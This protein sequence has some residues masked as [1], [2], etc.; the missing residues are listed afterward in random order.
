MSTLWRLQLDMPGKKPKFTH[1]C[2]L[3]SLCFRECD[4][5]SVFCI[6]CCFLLLV[7]AILLDYIIC[8]IENLYNIFF[9]EKQPKHIPRSW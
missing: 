6:L 9:Y 8:T 4:I 7:E 2:V 3:F 5:R 1:I